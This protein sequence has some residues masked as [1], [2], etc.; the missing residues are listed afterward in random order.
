VCVEPI[1]AVLLGVLPTLLVLL[2]LAMGKVKVM[3]S[4]MAKL[5]DVL[6]FASVLQMPTLGVSAPGK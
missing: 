1:L 6:M 5:D 4:L 3:L 2:A